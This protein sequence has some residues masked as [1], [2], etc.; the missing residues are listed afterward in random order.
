M[1]YCFRHFFFVLNLLLNPQAKCDLLHINNPQFTPKGSPSVAGASRV[2]RVCLKVSIYTR[3]ISVAATAL[4]VW[5]PLSFA[6]F[7]HTFVI[8]LLLQMAKLHYLLPY[9]VCCT[10]LYFL[11]FSSNEKLWHIYSCFCYN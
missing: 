2:T 1:Q 11:S 5:T 7:I 10:I 9:Y 6:N 4:C 8:F 3:S